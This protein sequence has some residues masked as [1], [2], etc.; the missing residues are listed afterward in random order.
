M[1]YLFFSVVAFLV[2]AAGAYAQSNI[3]ESL[4][5]RRAGEGVVTVHQDAQISGMIGKRYVLSPSEQPNVLRT[6]GFRVQVYA[7]N[8]SRQARSQAY[9]V[10]AKVKEEFPDMPVYTY[11]QP[12]RWLCRVGDYKTMEEAHSAM[13]MLKA[14]G[15]FK[16]VSIVREQI[17]IPIE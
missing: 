11:F 9:D 8:N 5:T 6:R 15:V 3:I 4:Q 12:P 17:N 10:A 16:E 14:T 13:R 1:K 7:G 2:S